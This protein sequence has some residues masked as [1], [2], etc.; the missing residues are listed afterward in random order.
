MSENDILFNGKLKRYFNLSDFDKVFGKSDSIKLVSEGESCHTIFENN[1]GSF[2][3]EDKYF[4]KDG[5][6]FENSRDKVAVE[7]FRFTKNNFIV[8]K[9]IKLTADTT[10]N[11]LT[12]IFPIATAN[13]GNMDVYNEG[14]LQVIQLLEDDNNTSDGHINLFIKNNKLYFMHWWFPC[15]TQ[16]KQ[17]FCNMSILINYLVL[18]KTYKRLNIELLLSICI[19]FNTFIYYNEPEI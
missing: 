15:L 11:D 19:L 3:P 6:T 4:Y 5:S 12:K 18:K 16:S 17:R 14:K 9:G 2:H 10:T 13:I 1:D 8:F 7:E